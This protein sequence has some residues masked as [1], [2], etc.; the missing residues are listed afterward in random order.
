MSIIIGVVKFLSKV[1]EKSPVELTVL[2]G[3]VTVVK[4][5]FGYLFCNMSTR[6]AE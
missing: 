2:S 4:V 5:G 3:I 6:I 1:L